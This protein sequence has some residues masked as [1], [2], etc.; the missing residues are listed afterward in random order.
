MGQ[1]LGGE[2]PGRR[3]A[4]VGED[5]GYHQYP[6]KGDI[7]LAA[8]ELELS[9]LAAIVQRA[10]QE[11]TPQRALASA[12]DGIV[13][14]TIERRKAVGT[15]LNDPVARRHFAAHA[16]FRDVMARLRRLLFP[17]APASEARIGAAVLIAAISG[18]ATHPYTAEID[19]DTLRHELTQLAAAALDRRR[20]A[21]RSA[22]RR[23]GVKR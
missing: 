10:E 2:D 11:P 17:D 6:A 21:S 20:P 12:V 15:F 9:R 7:V 13:E 5:A 1:V 23:Q 14:L 16:A 8:A 19:D 3:R 4:H 18:A 22:A